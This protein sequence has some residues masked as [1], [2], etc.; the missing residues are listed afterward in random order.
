MK[1]VL[2][3]VTASHGLNEDTHNRVPQTQLISG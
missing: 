3:K 1:V 2:D